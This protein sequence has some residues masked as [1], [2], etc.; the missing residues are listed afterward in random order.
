MAQIPLTP[1]QRRGFFAAGWLGPGWDGLVHLCAGDGA[2]A[3]RVAPRSGIPGDQSHVGFYGGLLFA[4]F[5]V[6]WGCSLLWGPIFADRFGRVRSLML[7]ILCYSIFTFLGA[8]ATNVWMLAAFRLL[9][10]V[11]IGSASGPWAH[12]HCRRVTGIATQDGRRLDATGYYFGIFLAAI[13]KL[14]YRCSLWLARDVFS[15]RKPC[16]A[17]GLHSLRRIRIPNGGRIASRRQ[18]ARGPC[19]ACS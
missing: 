14:F 10:G 8:F 17:G 12:L 5:L 13:A 19:T 18:V 2:C 1:N 3:A 11:G 7:T 16:F 15:R 9:A 6:G 4:L